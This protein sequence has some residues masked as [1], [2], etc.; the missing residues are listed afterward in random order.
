MIHYIVYLLQFFH[1]NTSNSNLT[2]PKVTVEGATNG[3][4]VAKKQNPKLQ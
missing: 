4:G 1:L 2:V 3:Q